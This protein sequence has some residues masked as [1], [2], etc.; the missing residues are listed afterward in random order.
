MSVAFDEYGRPFIIIR[1]QQRKTRLKGVDAL[2]SN[3]LAARTVSNTLKTSIG[4]RGMDKVLVSPDGDITV[5]NDGATI[6][7]Q[8]DVQH[9]IAKLMVELSKSQDDEI[10]DGTTGVVVLAGALL[11]EAEKLLDRGLHPVR[12][13]AGFEKAAEFAISKLDELTDKI[14]FGPGNLG[15]LFKTA[16]TT[17][18]SKILNRCHD[19][20]A[21]MAVDAVL[22]VA[23]LERGD[24]NFDHIKVDGKVGGKLEDSRLVHGIV[25]DKEMSHPQMAKSVKDAKIA[26][27][28]CPFEP[29]KPKTK[30]KLDI[31]SVEKYQELHAAEQNYFREMVQQVKDSGATLVVSQWGL[32]DEANH[33]LAKAEL[34]TLRWV[35]GV[36]IELL[37]MATGAR[38]V[39]RFSELTEAK[40]G[41]AGTVK[42]ISFG[43]TKDRM[44]LIEG[45]AS[46]KAVTVFVRGGNKMMIDEAKRSL[47]DALCVVRNL[48]RDNRIVYGGGATEIALSCAVSSEADK[49]KGLDQYAF[50]AFADALD[51]IPLALAE[52]SG[53]RPIEALASVKSR[54]LSENNFRLGID[55]NNVGT[56]DMREQNVF[57]T[58]IGKRQQILLASQVV[59]LICKIDDILGD[60]DSIA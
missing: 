50:R 45:C 28:T 47:H 32:D 30:H 3:I 7:E 8:M 4:P 48:V 12:I 53:L 57:E 9:E 51:T 42:E 15:P 27:L 19:Q 49:M 36:E 13:A 17:L 35:G 20:F 60:D 58:L 59:R 39:P 5:T 11:G 56:N 37:A 6:L 14:D 24:V 25:L 1:E 21:Q 31:D 23:D 2:K 33:L 16:K 18:S 41:H 55:C 10:G 38:I 43:T 44:V 52:N 34:P 46:T 54:Q 40:L 26:I 29:P 22:A